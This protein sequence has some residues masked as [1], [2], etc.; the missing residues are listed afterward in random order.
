MTANGFSRVEECVQ[1]LGGL[2]GNWKKTITGMVMIGLVAGVVA[3]KIQPRQLIDMG[4][5]VVNDVLDKSS[6]PEFSQPQGSI[7][8][9][10]K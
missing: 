5:K 2:S 6:T 4:K 3:G 10:T 7:R 8:E 9:K 1:Y